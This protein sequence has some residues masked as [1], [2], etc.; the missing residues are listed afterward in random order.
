MD[1]L[2]NQTHTNSSLS[3]F[4]DYAN[5]AAQ[6]LPE[7]WTP[8]NYRVYAVNA[9]LQGVTFNPLYTFLPEYWYWTK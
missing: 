7:I 6:Q 2:I 5:Y 3:V 1:Q 8:N 9:K 4:H